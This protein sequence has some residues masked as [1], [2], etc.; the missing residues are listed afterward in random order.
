[1]SHVTKDT[2][3]C[4]ID[5]DAK[6]GKIVLVERWQY[7]W[8]LGTPQMTRWTL[9]ERQ[10]FHARADRA[11]WNAWSN[12]AMLKVEGSSEF[13][14]SLSGRDI[15]VY[16]DIRW[17]T[18]KPHWTALVTKVGKETFKRSRVTWSIRQIELDTNDF[19]ER[20]E[21]FGPPKDIC[22]AQIPVAHE[23]GHTLGNIG[24]VHKGRSDEYDP[25]SL[26]SEDVA[27]MMH[28]GNELRS[29]HFNH[30]LDELQGMI[31]DTVFSVGR[32]Q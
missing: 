16:M 9:P 4:T 5:V 18:A 20:E 11:V 23:V 14:K 7:A 24:R 21:C 25:L 19:K 32:L 29:R 22:V 8:K 27:S 28:T 12:K 6:K 26:Y 30:L 2:S 31:P 15:P 3:W 17:V 1:M 10:A 13:A